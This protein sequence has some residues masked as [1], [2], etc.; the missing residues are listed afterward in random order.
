MIAM[1][2]KT[3][4]A[5]VICAP[6]VVGFMCVFPPVADNMVKNGSLVT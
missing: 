4:V 1:H 5:G 3:Y 6:A 2:V